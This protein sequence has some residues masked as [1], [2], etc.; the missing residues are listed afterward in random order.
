MSCDPNCMHQQS[1]LLPVVWKGVALLIE[2]TSVRIIGTAITWG[3]LSIFGTMIRACM[4]SNNHTNS[5][6]SV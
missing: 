1:V 2:N 4:V 5:I 3:S 6:K